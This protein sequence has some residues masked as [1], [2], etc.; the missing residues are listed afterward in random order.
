MKKLSFFLGAV[1]ILAA[2]CSNDEVI[3]VLQPQGIGFSTFVDNS[4][5]GADVTSSTL[6]DFAVW[7]VTW[8]PTV[9][10]KP[11]SL[12]LGT[13]VYLNSNVWTYA[14]L[15]FWSEGDNYRF[16]ALAPYIDD[17]A[18]LN[19]TQD[20]NDIVDINAVKGGISIEFD[21]SKAAANKDLCYAFNTVEKAK[22]NQEAV[23]LIFSHM[24]SR[25]KFTFKNGF[26]SMLSAIQITALKFEKAT[27]KAKINK[28]NEETLWTDI[29]NNTT[30]N[31]DFTMQPRAEILTE[32]KDY[33]LGGSGS[34]SG[35][36]AA[37]NQQESDH[38]YVFPLTEKKE[39]E[40]TFTVTLYNYDP[41][42][43]TPSFAFVKSYDH[44]VKLPID[45]F[46]P[47]FSY[48]FIAEINQDNIDPEGK[49]NPIEFNP[50][51][52]DWTEFGVGENTEHDIT[53]QPGTGGETGGDTPTNP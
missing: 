33:M 47:N 25:V 18:M 43:G 5:R 31:I 48:N 42:P 12:F 35:S 1:A 13:K 39:Y 49:L 44:R 22:A 9:K 24:L 11:S 41:T 20:L 40:V 38:F 27:P 21:N 53:P 6:K 34:T 2:S 28:V 14:P 23:N 29:S 3:D 15:K 8:S 19:V 51:V 32:E 46:Q 4:T 30:F 17:A 37:A 50:S 45:Q 10:V 16:S 7:G 52:S 36:K 26:P